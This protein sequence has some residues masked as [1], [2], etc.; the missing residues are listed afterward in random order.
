MKKHI[1]VLFFFLLNSPFCHA[2]NSSTDYKK[3]DELIGDYMLVSSLGPGYSREI[4][5]EIIS[6]FIS[7][8]EKDAFLYWDLYKTA[9]DNQFPPFSVK[10]YIAKVKVTY[11]QKQPLLNYTGMKIRVWPDARFAS[12][13][14][15]KTNMIMDSDEKPVYQ[16]KI[17]LK[18]DVDLSRDQPLIINIVRDNRCSLVRSISVGGNF[19]LFST[20]YHAVT[21]HPVIQI[22]INEH[23]SGVT[24]S[25]NI[26]YQRGV[27]VEMRF[28][29]RAKEELLFSTGF[30]YS[31][32]SL[33]SSMKDYT[34]SYSDTLDQQTG[35]PFTCTTF[36]RSPE[37]KEKMEV[38]RLEIPLSLKMYIKKGIYIKGGT[39]LGLVTS[40]TEA[41]YHLSRTGGGFVTMLNTHEQTYLDQDHELDDMQYGYYRN[42]RFQFPGK[43]MMNKV[44]LSLQLAAGFETRINYFCFGIE[45]NIGFGMNPFTMRNQPGN[46][47]LGS[48]GGF[49]S[50]VESVKM[51]A[52][53]YS[54]GIRLLVS[55][56]FQN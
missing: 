49:H 28:D 11:G 34:R 44:I 18:V 47:Q 24:I 9:A 15:R 35:I 10:E 4:S 48:I 29:R 21:H 45:P 36:E 22:G 8:F 19:T 55:Y 17:N 14:L 26:L 31:R 12:V 32:T 1:P 56:L 3:V 27:M 43:H 2:Q 50:I 6:H 46:Y 39:A 25:H 16:N 51:P 37:V 41:D 38:V 13:Y 23:F 42:K 52:F 40:S 33:S 7:L 30:F 53:E 20:P 54:F 5:P